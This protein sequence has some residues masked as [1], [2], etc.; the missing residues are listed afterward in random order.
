MREILIKANK[1]CKHKLVLFTIVLLF[2]TQ[3]S[4]T[5]GLGGLV[6][7]YYLMIAFLVVAGVIGLVIFL[8]H[9][10][11]KKKTKTIKA[12]TRDKFE[13]SN[14]SAQTPIESS[15]QSSSVLKI[16]SV[17]HIIIFILYMLESMYYL[18]VYIDDEK[19]YAISLL[20]MLVLLVVNS[21]GLGTR[22]KLFGYHFGFVTAIIILIHSMVQFN[23]LFKSNFFEPVTPL[24]AV[25]ILLLL[26]AKK[27]YFHNTKPLTSKFKALITGAGLI[28]AFMLLSFVKLI[29]FTSSNVLE[30]Q[31]LNNVQEVE[32][33][34]DD[35]YVS[36]KDGQIFAVI[37]KLEYSSDYNILD[38]GY[39]KMEPD[40]KVQLQENSDGFDVYVQSYSEEYVGQQLLSQGAWLSLPVL[41]SSVNKYKKIKVAVIQKKHW[42]KSEWQLVKALKSRKC[43]DASAIER[44][45]ALI[46]QGANDNDVI[47]EENLYQRFFHDYNFDLKEKKLHLLFFNHGLDVNFQLPYPY[48][49]DY[50]PDTLHLVV[51]KIKNSGSDEVS[52]EE[53]GYLQFLFDHG[54]DSSVKNSNAN[55]ALHEAVIA[56]RFSLA[57]LLVSYG[58]DF[59]INN[60]HGHTA[61]E[62]A[63]MFLSRTGE[64]DAETQTDSNKHVITGKLREN[65]KALLQEMR[66]RDFVDE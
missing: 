20:L 2:S 22:S 59:K 31:V 15:Q 1:T 10:S 37:K 13:V 16:F 36:F 57:K 45:G 39:E 8:A 3:T 21:I 51:E 12:D 66:L 33:V 63:M 26:P 40:R 44:I 47:I 19:A 58:A 30:N 61:E 46:K 23:V 32:E 62:I 18:E 38:G 28:M 9:R 43:C 29:V 27:Y 55:T 64:N 42:Q 49:S 54:I 25:L 48:N 4:A 5:T 7:L 65:L 41:S 53:K 24:Y 17:I 14:S 11:D 50:T 52:P 35:K 6:L 34:I 60:K 56:H